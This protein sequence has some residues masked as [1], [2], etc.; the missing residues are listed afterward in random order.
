MK[1]FF[2]YWKRPGVNRLGFLCRHGRSMQFFFFLFERSLPFGKE[3]KTIL[4]LSHGFGLGPVWLKSGLRQVEVSLG[5]GSLSLELGCRQE[6]AEHL[7]PGTWTRGRV[8]S[9]LREAGSLELKLSHGLKG[10][11]R[12]KEKVPIGKRHANGILVRL[13]TLGREFP[14]SVRCLSRCLVF[15]TN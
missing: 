5:L 12:R 7:G 4:K 15:A 10:W 9:F 1:L 2:I 8:S 11:V 13:Q 3:A 6:I 14:I